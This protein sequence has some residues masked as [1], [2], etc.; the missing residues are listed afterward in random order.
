MRVLFGNLPIGSTGASYPYRTS[1]SSSS[2]SNSSGPSETSS[3]ENPYRAS[4]EEEDLRK[5]NDFFGA[6]CYDFAFDHRYKEETHRGRVRCDGESFLLEVDGGSLYLSK[7]GSYLDGAG[8][9]AFASCVDDLLIHLDD[10]AKYFDISL[11]LQQFSS[12]L[13]LDF[14]PFLDEDMP[15]CRT[16]KALFP[17]GSLD[18]WHGTDFSF[19]TDANYV[20]RI[21]LDGIDSEGYGITLS[22]SIDACGDYVS[23]ISFVQTGFHEVDAKGFGFLKSGFVASAANADSFQ[24]IPERVMTSPIEPSDRIGVIVN[25]K[26]P[27]GSD[28]ISFGASQVQWDEKQER[29]WSYSYAGRTFEASYLMDYEATEE[30]GDFAKSIGPFVH[31]R[32][33][34]HLFF[35]QEGGI[36]AFDIATQEFEAFYPLDG[37]VLRLTEA[38]GAVYASVGKCWIGDQAFPGAIVKIPLDN[39]QRPWVFPTNATPYYLDVDKRGGIAFAAQGDQ[40]IRCFYYIDGFSHAVCRVPDLV[41]DSDFVMYN[42]KEDSFYLNHT[43]LTGGVRPLCYVYENGALVNRPLSFDFET[44]TSDY[45]YVVTREGNFMVTCRQLINVESWTSPV[46]LDLYTAGSRWG[47]TGI[48]AAAFEGNY[49]YCVIKNEETKLAFRTDLLGKR[50]QQYELP[51]GSASN[52]FYVQDG[53]MMIFDEA[54]EAFFEQSFD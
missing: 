52:L 34:G 7:N 14:V 23:P 9:K 21:R 16:F 33:G 19:S 20:R 12:N 5:L 35:A 31:A 43:K 49:L 42:E 22:L 48:V 32:P 30:P 28:S 17:D 51:A 40:W 15:L 24:V 25:D 1:S 36:S 11:Y 47:G 37:E 4:L 27:A 41:Y 44:P 39:L 53:K 29:H 10:K 8:F 3:Y 38:Q 18:F 54:K 45:G 13:L 46:A 50:M 2:R 6:T 26:L